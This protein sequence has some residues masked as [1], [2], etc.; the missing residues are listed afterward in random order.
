MTKGKPNARSQGFK[1][2]RKL[3][4]QILHPNPTTFGNDDIPSLNSTTV[5]N[6]EGAQR[7]ID[8]INVLH[9]SLDLVVSP[10]PHGHALVRLLGQNVSDLVRCSLVSKS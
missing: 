3:Q 7:L 8:T 5:P 10:N 2:L 4:D 9:Q 1:A 6:D